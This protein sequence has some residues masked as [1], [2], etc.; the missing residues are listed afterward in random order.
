MCVGTTVHWSLSGHFDTC[1]MHVIYFP[2]HATVSSRWW[3]NAQRHWVRQPREAVLNTAISTV[4]SPLYLWLP[5][6][7]FRFIVNLKPMKL[8]LQSPKSAAWRGHGFELPKGSLEVLTVLFVYLG[9]LVS[10]HIIA[11]ASH[12]PTPR[13]DGQLWNQR[14]QC[15]PAWALRSCPSLPLRQLLKQTAHRVV[16][17][18]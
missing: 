18:S 17:I 3:I 11:T 1:I 4:L 13:A 7:L 16:G 12:L 10:L 9:R 15:M 6:L 8:T 2:P 5:E 14:A